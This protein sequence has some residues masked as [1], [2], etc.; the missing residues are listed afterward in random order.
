MIKI[1]SMIVTSLI[2]LGIRIELLT[3]R[4][5]RECSTT[6]ASSSSLKHMIMTDLCSAWELNCEKLNWTVRKSIQKS[7]WI[8]L[9]ISL[10]E[11]SLKSKVSNLST[12]LGW[13]IKNFGLMLS[14]SQNILLTS[15]FSLGIKENGRSYR[16]FQKYI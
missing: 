4:I 9:K 14:L 2:M 13:L 12:R 6:W 8:E 3:S 5:R 10:I 15:Y 11:T 1:Y 7:N 16:I